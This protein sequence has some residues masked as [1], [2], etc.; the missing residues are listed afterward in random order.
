MDAHQVPPR[1][2]LKADYTKETGVFSIVDVNFGTGSKGFPAGKIK[3]LR[4][5]SIDYRTDYSKNCGLMGFSVNPIGTAYTSWLVKTLSEKTEKRNGCLKSI[6]AVF[7][8]L[9]NT[10]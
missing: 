6:W 1:R 8:Q 4:V 9:R 10:R 5:I 7:Y 2:A 3:K